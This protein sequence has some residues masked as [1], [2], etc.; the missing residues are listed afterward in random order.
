MKNDLYLFDIPIYRISPSKYSENLKDY[1]NQNSNDKSPPWY[2]DFLVNNYGGSWKYNEIIGYI[3]FYTNPTFDRRILGELWLI[4]SKTL[5]RKT[6]RKI[7]ELISHKCGFEIDSYRY[8]KKNNE[9][10][11]ELLS[12]T[13]EHLRNTEFKK[14]Y[15]D[16]SLF[17]STG[18]FINWKKLLNL[19]ADCT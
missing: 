13:L 18:P 4:K 6:R 16:D 3:R 10:I 19:N 1:I 14:Y 17:K 15:L 7:F 5:Y 12:S 8:E 11:F 9:E 2:H